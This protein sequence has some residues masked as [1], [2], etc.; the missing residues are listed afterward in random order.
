M[1]VAVDEVFYC[2]MAKRLGEQTIDAIH[3]FTRA[4]TLECS[5]SATTD[6]HCFQG[7]HSRKSRNPNIAKATLST[8][9]SLK[10][11]VP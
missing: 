2:L 5:Q 8:S 1:R 4:L 6:G 3:P 10:K 11:M 9:L 7:Q